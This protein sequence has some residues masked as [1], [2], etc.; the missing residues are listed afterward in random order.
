MRDHHAT[1]ADVLSA[2]ATTA[3]R[4]AVAGVGDRRPRGRPRRAG[5]PRRGLGSP[6]RPR[7]A[8]GTAR[9]RPRG[10]RRPLRRARRRGRHRGPRRRPG[11]AGRRAGAPRDGTGRGGR[12]HRRRPRA[13]GLRSERPR[14]SG[15]SASG[16]RAAARS[17]RRPDGL[18]RLPAPQ[19][20][21]DRTAQ[22]HPAGRGAAAA[23]RPRGRP[24]PR[25]DRRRPG[26]QPAPAVPRQRRGGRAAG[27]AALRR[28]RRPRRPVPPDRVL[29]ARRPPDGDVG[30]RRAG[31][32]RHPRAGARIRP[33]A[34]AAAVRPVGLR[35]T[36]GRRRC[37]GSRRA[38]ACPS[39][40]P[41]A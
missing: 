29:A 12:H 26:V 2:Q 13:P 25:A 10:L 16:R 19:L 6:G 3:P 37:T 20:R 32:R 14:L 41:T 23:R 17:F 39:W 36:A 30:Q 21:F 18:G 15:E 22:G 9:H 1:L 7:P 35:P 28:H 34:A 11:S 31:H 40:S 5:H 27:P 4:A 8:A 33:R 24:Q 38:T